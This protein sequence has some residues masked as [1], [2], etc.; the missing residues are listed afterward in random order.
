MS[1]PAAMKRFN[2]LSS[3]RKD[4]L[5]AIEKAIDKHVENLTVVRSDQAGSKIL[6]EHQE[7]SKYCEGLSA[8]VFG[9]IMRE[10]LREDWIK[11]SVVEK[12]NRV[13][14]YNRRDD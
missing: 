1:Y 2:D 10:H 11:N 3:E 12:G 7:F 14:Y 9:I 4:L 8:Q 13:N 5:Q 6:P